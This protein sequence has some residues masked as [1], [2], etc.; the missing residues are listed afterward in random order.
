MESALPVYNEPPPPSRKRIK[1]NHPCEACRLQR[2]KCNPQPDGGPCQRC[3]LMRRECVYKRSTVPHGEPAEPTEMELKMLEE[4]EIV[5]EEL[6]EL[7]SEVARISRKDK[8]KLEKKG[9]D[10]DAHNCRSS[11]SFT[12]LL[13]VCGYWYYSLS[14]ILLII[15]ASSPGPISTSHHLLSGY[16]MDAD[17]PLDLNQ[18]MH[19]K[20][21]V[22]TSG[23]G[24]VLPWDP[25][26]LDILNRLNWTLTIRSGR[27]RIK[28]NIRNF[29]DLINVAT[30]NFDNMHSLDDPTN[31]LSPTYLHA[32]R[33][34]SVL[35]VTTNHSN[36]RDASITIVK[37]ASS[38]DIQGDI[39]SNVQANIENQIV[40]T[41]VDSFFACA[42]H[43]NPII[44]R[45]TF[46]RLFWKPKDPTSSPVVAALCA[47]TTMHDCKNS[48][49]YT[50]KVPIHLMGEHFASRARDLFEDSF[51]SPTLEAMI[52]LLYMIQYRVFSLDASK[53]SNYAGLAISMGDAL[54]KQ[55]NCSGPVQSRYKPEAWA[56][57]EI[58]KRCFYHL[59]V[60]ILRY[61]LLFNRG[62]LQGIASL[63]GIIGPLGYP[64]PL[65]D[66]DPAM[67]V[68]VL[69]WRHELVLGFIKFTDRRYA[70]ASMVARL[71]DTLPVDTC[72]EVERSLINW[73]NNLHPEFRV[74]Q[75]IFQAIDPAVLAGGSY[76]PAVVTIIIGFY[77]SWQMIHEHFLPFGPKGED[78]ARN[79]EDTEDN[80]SGLSLRSLT[81]CVKASAIVLQLAEHLYERHF[82]YFNPHM[83]MYSCDLYYRLTLAKDERLAAY[84]RESLAKG[85]HLIKEALEKYN[86]KKDRNGRERN[87]AKYYMKLKESLQHELGQLGVK[88]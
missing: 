22:P 77:D 14:T 73:Y 10:D 48:L 88:F 29:Q 66:E 26:R 76:H 68:A 13:G 49:P 74:T 57:R 34:E 11:A 46:D 52:G 67:R 8:V 5:E 41:L 61:Q 40:R 38:T 85:L 15:T 12:L 44:H 42:N 54:S 33:K 19:S 43:T 58:F 69:A 9:E 36:L 78:N 59:F 56:E 75:G 27:M 60:S 72:S 62:S 1:R 84:G 63:F 4:V 79:Q 7:E 55:L 35:R 16:S 51:D 31:I 20:A 25:R 28:T 23:H 21:L 18:E 30:N 37:Y 6:E 47:I 17:P 50:G 71:S 2:R 81:I 65:P 64:E 83:L 24:T 80:P 3:R 82:C 32:Q 53:A 70:V 45:P 39:F 87:V 86:S